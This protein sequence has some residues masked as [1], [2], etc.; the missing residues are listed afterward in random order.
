MQHGDGRAR[1]LGYPTANL[2]LGNYQRPRYGVYGVQVLRDD[3]WLSAIANIGVR[4]TFAGV[5]REWVEVHIPNFS[6]DLYGQNLRVQFQNFIR[7][8]KNLMVSKP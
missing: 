5:L 3:K 8:N 6:G 4:P 7:P 2:D 1:G